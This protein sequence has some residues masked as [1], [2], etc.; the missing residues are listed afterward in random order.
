MT[1]Q[2]AP[3][4]N[5]PQKRGG[6]FVLGFLVYLITTAIV[7]AAVGFFWAA[8]HFTGAGPLKEDT[9]IAVERGM[10]LNQIATHLEAENAIDSKYIFILGARF[11]GAA[12]DLKA[13]EYQ[14]E[15]GISA[16]DIV[17]K[18]RNH[19]VF[20]RFVTVREGLTSYEVVVLLNGY[21]ELIPR[22]AKSLP[23]E[24]SLLPQT[25]SYQLGEEVFSV[26]DRM[27]NMMRDEV[28]ALCAI[29]NP[30]ELDWQSFISKPCGSEPLKNVGDVLT[31][32]SIIEKETGV[33]G[34]RAQVAGVFINRLNRG[35]PL[36]TDPTVIYA[37]TKGVH[38]NDGKGPL[39]RRLLRKDLDYDSPYNT[40]KYA[41]LP[42]GPIA[43]PGKASIEAALNPEAHDYIY[44][45]ADGSGGH[46][47]AKTLREHNNNV[48]KWR[49]IRREQ[50]Q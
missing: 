46:S 19:D 36:Q 38:K 45:V 12:A 13:G 26:L 35:I 44:F 49:K 16:K 39:G 28:G 3:A 37:I 14:L 29:E 9:L 27:Q 6:R 30:R 23:E 47:F 2:P 1:E 48:A 42:P 31:L 20:G 33:A 24:G 50:A 41:G 17:A 7:V 32:A 15:P 21:E 11:L 5:T 34:E 43:N 18:M 25:Y 4:E 40:Y 8:Q 10:G 22:R